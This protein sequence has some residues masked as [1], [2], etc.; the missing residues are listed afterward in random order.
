MERE[1]IARYWIAR[2]R[3]KHERNWND[4][5]HI[6][7]AEA[8]AGLHRHALAALLLFFVLLLD[9]GQTL[10]LIQGQIAYQQL[11]VHEAVHDARPTAVAPCH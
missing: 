5:H 4:N 7:T 9:Q 10:S 2:R 6:S 11:I 1:Q 3:D 8:W